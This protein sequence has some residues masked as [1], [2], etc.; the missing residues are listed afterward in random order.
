MVARRGDERELRGVRAPLH[1]DPVVAAAYDVVAER[2]AVRIRWY[3]QPDDLPRVDVDDHA[4]DREDVLV[5]GQRVLPGLQPWM[6]DARVDEIHFARLARV[7]LKR[8]DPLRVRRP[9]ENRPV[10]LRP[11]G[12]VGGVA[13]VLF[14]VGRELR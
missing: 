12:V 9:Q 11:P 6:A 14:A 8:G 13:V 10:A 4:R 7:V 5:P 2:R 3:L 1:V